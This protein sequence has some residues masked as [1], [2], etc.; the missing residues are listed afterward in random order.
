ADNGCAVA[1]VDGNDDASLRVELAGLAVVID[2]VEKLEPRGMVGGD[3]RELLLDLEPHLHRIDADTLP[4]QAGDK[5]VRPLLVVNDPAKHRRHLQPAL[6]VD[7]GWRASSE[8][9]FLHFGPQ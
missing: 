4:R 2:A 5:D 9:F 8:T 7:P 1:Q 3:L 6:V